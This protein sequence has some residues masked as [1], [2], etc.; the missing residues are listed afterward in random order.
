MHR[1]T[2]FQRPH[3]FVLVIV[4]LMTSFCSFFRL[5]LEIPI[6]YFVFSIGNRR[7]SITRIEHN[8]KPLNEYFSHENIPMIMTSEKYM[9]NNS[10]YS[11][12]CAN[13]T[14]I[15]LS[16]SANDDWQFQTRNDE[17]HYKVPECAVPCASNT[18]PLMNSYA[19]VDLQIQTRNGESYYT[20]PRKT[21]VNTVIYE[22]IPLK[23]ESDLYEKMSSATCDC[24]NL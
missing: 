4:Q 1:Y 7:K 2:G 20:V 17:T 16:V 13:N 11:V 22:E 19:N 10:E 8:V 14:K 23:W 21:A 15:L 12:P 5:L 6:N 18:K 3:I 24:S 9:R